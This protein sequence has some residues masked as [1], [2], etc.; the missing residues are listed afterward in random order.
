MFAIWALFKFPIIIIIVITND[1][2]KIF[3]QLQKGLLQD[4]NI[5]NILVVYEIC[6][7]KIQQ[8]FTGWPMSAR[9]ICL[10]DRMKTGKTKDSRW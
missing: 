2:I 4:L 10:I 1:V 8:T 3:K 6:L 5:S 7:S 9:V